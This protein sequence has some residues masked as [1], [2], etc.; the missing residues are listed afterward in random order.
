M[1]LEAGKTYLN[2]IGER[3]TVEY[4]G[5]KE[6]PFIGGG[7]SFKEDGSFL[8]IRNEYR[9]DLISEVIESKEKDFVLPEK[10][11]VLRTEENHEVINDYFKNKYG[12][13]YNFDIHYVHIGRPHGYS[14]RE[15]LLDGYTEIT[16]EQFKEHV[17]NKKEM[18]QIGW[19]LKDDCK[20]YE[21]SA[22]KIAK[23]S[24]FI[25][26]GSGCS[27]YVGTFP[28]KYLKEAGVLE[29]WFELVYEKE[30]TYKVGDW[31]YIMADYCNDT[32]HKEF[33][34]DARK[35]DAIQIDHFSDEFGSGNSNNLKVA[36]SKYGQVVYIES[37][38]KDFRKATPQEIEEATKPKEIIHSVGGKFDVKI[39][40]GKIWHKS[41]DITEFV[42][43]MMNMFEKG[44]GF[45][46]G[47][48]EAFVIDVKFSRTGC[49]HIPTSLSA[50]KELWKVYQ[51]TVN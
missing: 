3:V 18:K 15:S 31:I 50:W 22:R 4:I 44:R 33:K 17:L 29:L 25:P 6:Y 20:Q 40:H 30:E 43:N 7:H 14:S 19:K 16:F 41:D 35:G 13:Y 1:K 38:P 46:W 39:K 11:A 8:S 21:E 23:C 12:N 37:Y 10:W 28:E 42:K 51:E 24:N 32:L 47:G 49:Q 2:R 45:A 9:L 27:F 26:M 5:N 48:Y 36:V 34:K